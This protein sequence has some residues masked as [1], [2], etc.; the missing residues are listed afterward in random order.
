MKIAFLILCHTDEEHIARLVNKITENEN[1]YAFIHVDK[2]SDIKKFKKKLDESESVVF[3]RN[4]YSISWGG[5]SAIEATMELIKYANKYK[6]FDRYVLLQGLDYPIKSNE[7]IYKYFKE[8]ANVEFIRGCN[9]TESKDKYFYS[10]CRYYLFYE[11]INRFKKIFNK[12]NYLLD[13]K[14]KSGYI[15]DDKKYTVYWGSAQWALTKECIEYI[16]KFYDKNK[17]FN[18]YFKYT[19]PVDE[20]YFTSIVFNSHFNKMTIKHGDEKEKRGLVNWRN[21]HYF[22]YPKEIKVFSEK[23][24]EKLINCKELFCRKV[25]TSISKALLDKIDILHLEE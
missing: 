25:N 8:N 21:I 13:L 4:R 2:K 24:Y 18:E 19:F 1:F 12:L 9:I 23:D 20:L 6:N 17:K 10:R 15:Y 14:L 22:E 16:I 5:Y 3:L 11:N 7:Y